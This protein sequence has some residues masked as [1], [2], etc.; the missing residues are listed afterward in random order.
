MTADS[1]ISDAEWH[2]MEV[3]WSLGEATAAAIIEELARSTTWNHRT[4]RTLLRRLVEKEILRKEGQG[5]GS[6]YKALVP[7]NAR[8]KSEG[9]S[10][11]ERMFQ[12]DAAS[13]MLHFAK[14]AKLGPEKL[15]RLRELLDDESDEANA[16]GN[17]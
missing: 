10:F 8:V 12:G 4:I 15:A 1:S 7:R 16:G 13:L 3:V 14:E 11:L 17:S 6:V 9:K 2:V 5:A